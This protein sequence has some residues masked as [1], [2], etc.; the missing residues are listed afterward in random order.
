[1]TPTVNFVKTTHT[2]V[3]GKASKTTTVTVFN[4]KGKALGKAKVASNRAYSVK[5]AKQKKGT[6]LYVQSQ[7]SI[8]NFN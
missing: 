8:E 6:V 3:T 2:K 4:A 1:V 7:D 5:I